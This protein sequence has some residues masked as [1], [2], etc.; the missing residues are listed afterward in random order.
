MSVCG[1]YYL[2]SDDM[3]AVITSLLRSL[4][5]GNAPRAKMEGEIYPGDTAP[6]LA[7]N[8]AR[9]LRA[10]FM[11][12]GFPLNNKRVITARSETAAQK[13]MFRESMQLRRCIIPASFYYEW[14][15]DDHTRYDFRPETGRS[16][17]LAGIYRPEGNGRYSYTVLTRDA[18][19][20]MRHLHPRM[21]VI[22]PADSLIPWLTPGYDP[23]TLIKASRTDIRFAPAPQLPLDKAPADTLY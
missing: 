19:P 18:A 8:R 16:L 12:W 6:V 2:K 4:D 7:N 10:F 23:D 9:M 1:R 14:A 20:H 13:S 22:L 5:A 3:N 17:L 11:D 15:V 21:P